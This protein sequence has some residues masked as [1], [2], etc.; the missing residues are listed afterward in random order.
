VERRRL[1]SHG[2]EISVV[3]YGAWGAGGEM[4]GDEVPSD[5]VRDAMRA[6]IEAGVN[7]ID[8]AE[9]YG[10]GR[11]EIL[12]GDVVRDHRDGVLIFTK[13][14][15]FASGT[16]PEEIHKAIRGSLERLGVD[17]I[18]LYQ[19]HWPDE[20]RVPVEETWGAMAEC[21]D[22]GLARAIGVSNFDR[23]LV[24]RCMAIRHVDSVQNECSLLAPEDPAFLR[25][26]DEE[27][28]GFLAYGPLAYGLLTGAVTEETRFSENDW[29]SG[30]RWQLGYYERLFAPGAFDR[31]LAAVDRLRTI[32]E[33]E[34]I[35]LA[36]L[37]LRAL[38]SSDGV[39]AAIAGS[40]NPEHAGANAEA[41]DGL[42]APETVEEIRG[43]IAGLDS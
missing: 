5:R 29:R 9:A 3:G 8:T 4:W 24:E 35:P 14:A 30:E 19:I 33:R 27:G 17:A 40:R 13:V 28:V 22:E 43:A 31:N 37:A 42:L 16:R 38:L 20:E 18:D 1:G 15:P 39:T 2:P 10:D 34:G 6:A 25:W 7:W 41:G 12:A 23:G 11:S 21:V 32:A 36:T 26:L